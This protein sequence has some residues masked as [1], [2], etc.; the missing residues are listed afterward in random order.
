MPSPPVLLVIFNRAD[1][2]TQVI[3]AVR[4]A[5]PERIYIAAD[6]PRA[7]RPDE[8]QACAETRDAVLSRIDWP[9]ELFTLFREENMGCALAVSSAI[10]W[11]FEQEEMGIILEDDCVPDESFFHYCQQ[12]LEH[13]Q[14]DQRVL[15]ISG[16][17]DQNQRPR[18]AGTYYFSNFCS[19]WGWATW[20]RAWQ[21]FRLSMP[22]LLD[23]FDT[24]VNA[25]FYGNYPAGKRWLRSVEQHSIIN[26]SSWA[27][28]WAYTIHQQNGL[29][30]TSN[31]P[32]IKNIGFEDPR[33]THTKGASA[34]Q[35]IELQSVSSVKH[36]KSLLPDYEAD[37][38]TMRNRFYPP[39]L[40][41]IRYKSRTLLQK[42]M[43]SVLQ[44]R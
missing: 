40:T 9:S 12:L 34:Y 4:R 24:I 23:S 3:D 2:A 31:Y 28:S 41:R 30:L 11:F 37:R 39:L 17:N 25:R 26:R 22:D 13:Y 35:Q 19:V 7:D 8:K 38:L 27:Y 36:P 33:S 20:R 43:R 18:G 44:L 10:S 42:L 21:H 32:L 16:F 14:H 15:H 6:G 1:T 5:K 29:C